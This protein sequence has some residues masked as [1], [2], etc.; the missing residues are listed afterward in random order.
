MTIWINAPFSAK[1]MEL[2]KNAAAG[3]EVFIGTEY[4][5]KA[6][7]IVGQPPKDLSGV[8][9]LHSTNAGVERLLADIPEDVVIANVTG[10][11]GEVI[12]EYIIGGVLALNRNLLRYHEQQRQHI[13][14]DI[15]QGILL[16]GKNA[17]ILGCGD[18]GTSTAEKLRAFGMNVTGIRR[19]PVPTHGFDRVF[20]MNMLDELLPQTDL[21][22]CCLPHTSETVGLLSEKRI[23]LMKCGSILV[24]VGRGSLIDEASLINSLKSGK[25]AGAVLDVFGQEPLPESSPLWDMENVL[26]TPH[27]SGPS[28]G[29]FPEVERRIA[30]I[31]AENISKFLAGKPLVNVIDRSKGYADRESF[32]V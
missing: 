3:C 16:C 8:K 1:N 23:T 27:I 4:V 30:E 17:L 22:I 15:P 2:I 18:I 20:G 11:F 24:N 13:W 5:P 9:L 6:D 25:L 21:L 19:S 29:H 32:N 14:R 28:F 26:I 10:A 31:C 12:S 7:I